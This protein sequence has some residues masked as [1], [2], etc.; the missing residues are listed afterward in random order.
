MNSDSL[1]E[2]LT[3]LRNPERPD[4]AG[5]LRMRLCHSTGSLRVFLAVSAP[6][7]NAAIV[8][9]MPKSLIPAHLTA[10]GSRCF[11]VV[12]SE[13]PG[14]AAERG[15]VV[16]QLRDQQFEDLFVQL[17]AQILKEVS[18]ASDAASA[19]DAAIRVIDRW[20]RFLEKY[21]DILSSEEVRGLIGEIAI[22]ERLIRRI[23]PSAAL[24][25]WK[26][27]N[28]SILDF[29]CGDRS[30]EVKTFLMSDGASI[31]IND[32]LQLEPEPGLPLILACQEL[33]RSSQIDLA[34]P[35]HIARV[36][37]LLATDRLLREDFETKLASAGYLPTHAAQYDQGYTLGDLRVFDVRNGFP[38]IRAADVPAAVKHVQF[39]I[40][41]AHL[42]NFAVASED[43]IGPLASGTP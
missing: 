24:T 42:R 12:A 11:S 32:P 7:R 35:G 14:L 23:G 37:G 5:D 8:I 4:D 22:L 40:E 17:G 39:S 36:S 20:R 10:A 25:A 3:A 30:I 34:L 33:G 26:S 6:E 2:L 21:R 27:P 1:R 43:V 31:R 13:F 16:I 9:E 28:G 29:E 41:V 15:A 18:D 19:L 38:R